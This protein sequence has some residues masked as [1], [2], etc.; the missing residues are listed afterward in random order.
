MQNNLDQSG[1]DM[2]KKR[3]KNKYIVRKSVFASSLREAFRI[4]KQ[5]P[6][7]EVFYDDEWQKANA[8]EKKKSL[9]FH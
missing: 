5:F 8:E 4:E 7:E 1:W 9:G 2:A 3:F 6:A